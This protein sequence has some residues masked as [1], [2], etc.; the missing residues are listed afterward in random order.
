M[1]KSVK[2]LFVQSLKAIVVLAF[3]ASMFS[4]E[5]SVTPDSIDDKSISSGERKPTLPN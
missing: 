4:C 2:N 5:E 3:A 1:T